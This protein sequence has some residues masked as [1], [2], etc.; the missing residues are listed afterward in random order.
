MVVICSAN[1]S[2]SARTAFNLLSGHGYCVWICVFVA[3]V[4]DVTYNYSGCQHTEL[5]L[6]ATFG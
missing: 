4:L 3:F 1:V 2:V 5:G 6:L